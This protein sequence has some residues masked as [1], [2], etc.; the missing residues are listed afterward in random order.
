MSPRS[1]G[2]G[3]IYKRTDGRW[4][5]ATYVHNRTGGRQRRQV[6]GKS[7]EEVAAKLAEL[8]VMTANGIPA[9]AV[10]WTVRTYGDHWLTHVAAPSVKPSTL[11]NYQWV[12][13]SHVYPVVGSVRLTALAPMHVRQMLLAVLEKGS[14][15][16]TAQLSKAVLRAMLAEAMRDQ[17]VQR[18]VAML[19]RGPRVER[20]EVQP[21]SAAEATA[22]L[23]SVRD[24]RLAALFTVG[25]ALGLRKGELLA[26]RWTDVDLEDGSLRVSRTV[27][28]RGSG[29][30]LIEGS[31][32][33]ARSRRTVPLP[34]V[35][36][37][38]LQRHRVQ[39]ARDRLAAGDGWTDCGL[40]FASARGT[41]I[42]PRNLNRLFDELSAQAGLRRLRFHDL[43]H[44]CASLLLAQGVQPRVVMEILG[45]SQLSITTDLYSHVMPTALRG[46]ADL[47]DQA[48]GHS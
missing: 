12:L 3:S 29:I 40:V 37:E 44:T 4:A 6:Y 22:F 42:E 10:K 30:G 20:Q 19:V 8:R 34:A 2:E 31:P 45:H 38:A 18:N 47:L 35:C 26:L 7:K 13:T 5:G 48:L 41:V 28:R 25:V 46:A 24:H 11:S 1:R 14:S 27:Q 9:A 17:L 15:P 43:R 39:Q 33:S 16:R 32:K 23:A 36:L 21:W